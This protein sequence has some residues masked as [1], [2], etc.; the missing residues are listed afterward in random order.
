MLTL[1]DPQQIAGS[2]NRREAR[3]TVA[4]WSASPEQLP[5]VRRDQPKS[6]P[7]CRYLSARTLHSLEKQVAENWLSQREQA[8][9]ALWRDARRRQAW[10]WGRL[11]AKQMILP[12]SGAKSPGEIEILSRDAAGQVNRPVVYHAGRP[13][14]WSLSITHTERGVLAALGDDPHT[15]LGVDATPSDAV[16]AAVVR[17]WFTPAEQRWLARSQSAEIGCFIW[18]A[19]EALYKACNRGEGFNPGEIEILSH[20][21]S[22]YRGESLSQVSLRSWRIDGHIAVLAAVGAG[23]AAV[24]IEP[25]RACVAG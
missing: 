25:T 5:V 18:A 4:Q 13:T 24:G 14:D 21:E 6:E 12:R 17:R 8:E 7:E 15:S 19:K 1:S 2:L 23:R 9:L 3:A 16:S 10:T 11:L 20:G 22:K